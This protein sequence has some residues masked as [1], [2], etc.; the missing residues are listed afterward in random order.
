MLELVSYYLYVL[1]LPVPTRNVRKTTE[2]SLRHAHI[3][4]M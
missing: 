2:K 4:I 3:H 1:S